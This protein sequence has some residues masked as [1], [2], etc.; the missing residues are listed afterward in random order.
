V[1]ARNRERKERNGR[2]MD[3]GKRVD[4]LVIQEAE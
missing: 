4:G 1:E 3:I 2:E